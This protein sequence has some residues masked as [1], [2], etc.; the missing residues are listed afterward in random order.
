MGPKC[1]HSNL[2]RQANERPSS[3]TSLLQ[4]M[5]L[6]V[7]VHTKDKYQYVDHRGIL[8]YNKVTIPTVGLVDTDCNSNMMTFPNLVKSAINL[9][10]KKCTEDIAAAT[11]SQTRAQQ[12]ITKQTYTKHF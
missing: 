9:G 8:G 6:V 5:T 3:G 4:K 2:Q 11:T 7:T 10:Q 1:C 12:I